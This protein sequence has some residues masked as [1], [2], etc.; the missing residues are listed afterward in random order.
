MKTP[1][2][3]SMAVWASLGFFILWLM[4]FGL[5]SFQESYWLLMFCLSCLLGFLLLRKRRNAEPVLSKYVPEK[6][7]SKPKT[8][9]KPSIKKKQK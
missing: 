7:E 2:V 1:I 3:E 8:T 4:E 9:I 6:K 5:V